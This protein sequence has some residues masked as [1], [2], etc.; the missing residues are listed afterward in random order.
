MLLKQSLKGCSKTNSSLSSGPQ[1][2]TN[3]VEYMLLCIG[4]QGQCSHCKVCLHPQWLLRW[5]CEDLARYTPRPTHFAD[6]PHRWW[7]RLSPTHAVL[8]PI[9]QMMQMIL[10][11]VP[12]ICCQ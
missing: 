12:K 3:P 4:A 6:K 8:W 9:L 5:D 1:T 10:H 2:L 11:L 7:S